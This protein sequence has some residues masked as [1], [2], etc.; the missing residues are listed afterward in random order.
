MI[1]IAKISFTDIWQCQRGAGSHTVTVG[2]RV[3]AGSSPRAGLTK[4]RTIAALGLYSRRGGSLGLPKGLGAP[5]PQAGTS[6]TPAIQ[7]WM[8]EGE[9]PR[10]S[11]T[12]LLALRQLEL[13]AACCLSLAEDLEQRQE[14]NL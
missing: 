9:N 5:R 2:S 12:F 14:L 1:R 3:K 8:A 6:N 7:S 11:L 10:H 4:L 13:R